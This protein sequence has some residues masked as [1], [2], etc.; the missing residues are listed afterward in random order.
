MVVYLF[1]P[2]LP[3]ID[4]QMI[5]DAQ[6]DAVRGA[7][8]FDHIASS[9][10]HAELPWRTTRVNFP[11]GADVM[12]LPLASGLILSP[13]ILFDALLGWNLTIILLVYGSALATAWLAQLMS[14]SWLTGLFAG[15]VLLAQP[16][17]H[18]SLADGT[19]EHVAIWAVPLFIGA[20]WIALNE[21]NP[22]WGIG[23][24][25]FSIVVA[26]DS[27]YH[28]LYALILGTIVLPLALRTVKGRETDL[29]KATGAMF[30]AAVVGIGFIFSL[31]SRFESGEVGGP[32]TAVLQSTNATDLRL[33]WRYMGMGPGIRDL[34]RPPTLIPNWILTFT[35]LL[36][37]IGR[38]RSAPWLISGLLMIAFS[39]GT[40]ANTPELMG[41]WLGSWA[42]DITELILT[43]NQQFYDLP[44]AGEVRF[45]RRWLV[46]GA[47]SLA[48][49]ASIG[50]QAV[51][52]KWLRPRSLQLLVTAILSASTLYVGLQT[53]RL[54][55][56][57]PAHALPHVEFAQAIAKS[58]H[59]GAVL[60]L[61][62]TRAVEAGVTRE[63]LPVFANL[64]PSLASADDLYL[65][66]LH[67]RAMVSFPSLQ[68]LN[69][70]PADEDVARV[71]RDW[72]DLA[73]SKSTG[74]GIPP[75]AYDPGVKFQ[76][77]RGLRK[78]QQADLHWIAVDLGAYDEEGLGHL[79]N[80]LGKKV[81]KQTRFD[82][83][84]GVLLLELSPAPK[85]E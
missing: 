26:L 62:A 77:N 32:G 40:R 18:H 21:Q 16:M 57:F 27:P 2:A 59:E 25:L 22:K 36:C 41:A 49:G 75:S 56:P 13:M 52:Q 31:Y 14:N 48:V 67:N 4:T 72:S 37:L 5:G 24:G 3:L 9:L 23:A 85:A 29:W 38:R 68:T 83:G 17:M 51:F 60:L 71:L 20:S 82:E 84:D 79:L 34:S 61:P 73:S 30:I 74:R 63:K 12:V 11:F 39:F 33:W 28:G 81:I 45:P 78:L 46:P 10:S 43:V 58:T 64:G 19:A 50:L 65:Q 69:A 7:W 6:T 66:I 42:T 54:H 55:Q 53:S 44:I 15:A 1:N 47:L 76:R 8:G 80:Q 35:V 70:S